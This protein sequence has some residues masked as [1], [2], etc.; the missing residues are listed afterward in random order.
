MPSPERDFY[1][2]LFALVV[3]SFLSIAWFWMLKPFLGPLFWAGLLAILL[4]PA[5]QALRHGLRGRKGLAALLLTTAVV[6]MVVLPAILGTS[7]VIAQ[8][9]DLVVR[10]QAIAKEYH[11]AGPSDVFA[12]PVV[13]QAIDW[14]SQRVPI[15]A[16]QAQA[17]LV[18][19]GQRVLELLLSVAGSLFTG[20]LGVFANIVLGLFLFFFFLR[21]GETMMARLIGLIPLDERRKEPLVRHLNDVT[22]A[23][24]LGSL[25]TALVQGSL[26][27]VAFAIAGLA[28]P[29]VFG[30]LAMVASLVPVVGAALVW[31]P[32]ALVLAGQRRWGWAIFLTA[33]CVGLVHSSDNFIRPLFISSRA[34]ISTLPVFVGL[35]GGVS[36]FGAIG[37]FLGPVLVALALAL[38]EYWEEIRKADAAP[39][40]APT[41]PTG[42]V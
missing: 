30:A 41:A 40:P 39:G 5:N 17:W 21:D 33:W 22:T 23:V 15:T 3:L 31:V 27:G 42:G 8:A 2:R 35:I 29:A 13:N 1:S 14:V 7:L 18:Q 26:V 6:L 32:A 12:L 19:G 24:V 25:V 28:A 38:L 11:V 34:K 37:M 9:S 20:V 10:L 16:E 36:A 4:F